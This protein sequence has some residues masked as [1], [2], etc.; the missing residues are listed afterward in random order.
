[1]RYLLCF[2][3]CKFLQKVQ[4]ACDFN[5]CS[6]ANSF[7]NVV[8]TVNIIFWTIFFLP[9]C[10]G[11]RS[12][13]KSYTVFGLPSTKDHIGTMISGFLS[14][15][16]LMPSRKDFSNQDS[17]KKCYTA[18]SLEDVEPFRR[19]PIPLENNFYMSIAVFAVYMPQSTEE[20]W[21]GIVVTKK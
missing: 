5:L 10:V 6:I 18:T 19:E 14:S 3:L 15:P 9:Y 13:K 16:T 7:Q 20:L 21:R 8:D 17:A 12:T 11:E 4:K 1:M 2:V